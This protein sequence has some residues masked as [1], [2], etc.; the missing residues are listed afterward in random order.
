LPD[1]SRRCARHDFDFRELR[2]IQASYIAKKDT[3]LQLKLKHNLHI[4]PINKELYFQS[5]LS[6]Q[7]QLFECTS[8][9]SSAWNRRPWISSTSVVIST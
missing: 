7:K 6:L 3:A 1:S 8:H 5:S 9:S 4:L 2:E